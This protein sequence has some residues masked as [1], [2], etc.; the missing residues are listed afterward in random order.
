MPRASTSR[1]S[2]GALLPVKTHN[3]ATIIDR[4]ADHVLNLA[5]GNLPRKRG[6][7]NPRSAST[8]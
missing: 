1:A 3:D 6:T 4:L 8:H 2:W 5:V 7:L